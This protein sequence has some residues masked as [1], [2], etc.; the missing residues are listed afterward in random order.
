MKGETNF[1]IEMRSPVY[2]KTQAGIK[3]KNVKLTA[4]R[5]FLNLLNKLDIVYS[6]MITRLNKKRVYYLGFLLKS[7]FYKFSQKNSVFYSIG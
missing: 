6:Q 3:R 4:E 2:T 7:Y 1:G 5:L